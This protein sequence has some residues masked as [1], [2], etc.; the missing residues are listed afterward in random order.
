MKLETAESLGFDHV[1]EQ[2]LREVFANG[3]GRLQTRPVESRASHLI[4]VS[5]EIVP[6]AASAVRF[7]LVLL[8]VCGLFISANPNVPARQKS[9]LL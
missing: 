5:L 6:A 9:V 1:T 7:K 3:E 4:G 2:Q 8:A